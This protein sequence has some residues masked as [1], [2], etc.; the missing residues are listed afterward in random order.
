MP[1][2][3]ARIDLFLVSDQQLLNHGLGALAER[4]A[5]ISALNPLLLHL[6]EGM[7]WVSNCRIIS[8]TVTNTAA[9]L[10]GIQRSELERGGVQEHEPPPTSLVDGIKHRPHTVDIRRNVCLYQVSLH[11]HVRIFLR[12]GVAYPRSLGVGQESPIAKVIR[13]DPKR[14]HGIIRRPVGIKRLKLDVGDEAG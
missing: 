5:Q 10:C 3:S 4:L 12:P 14:V 13:S 11:S 1:S 2:C 9:A 8:L 7:R 6:I